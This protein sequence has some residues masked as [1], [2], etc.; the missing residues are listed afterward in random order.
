MSAAAVDAVDA[1]LRALAPSSVRVGARTIDAADEA[2]LHPDEAAIVAGAVAKRRREFATGRA[3]LRSLLGTDGPVTVLATRAPAVPAGVVA[4]LAH[5]DEL[6]VAVV[7]TDPRVVAVGIDVEPEG[8][9]DGEVAAVVLRPE[10]HG[11]DPT[12]VFVVKE[13]VYKAWSTTG[14]RMLGHD[15]V[16]VTPGAQ[17]GFTAMVLDAHR[18]FTGSSARVGGRVVALVVD[19]RQDGSR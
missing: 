1:A 9:V 15:D 13:A 18:E 6:A 3:L 10:E 5:D 7:S 2:G 16:R 4:S 19:A 8:A 12:W 17:G 11:L 14:G